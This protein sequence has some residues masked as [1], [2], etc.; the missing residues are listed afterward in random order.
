MF[1]TFPITRE[2]RLSL[3][4]LQ[5]FLLKRIQGLDYESLMF[6]SVEKRDAFFEDEYAIYQKELEQSNK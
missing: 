5:H 1:Y 3:E 2:P 4:G 6:M